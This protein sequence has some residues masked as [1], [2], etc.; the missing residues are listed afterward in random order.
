LD[1]SDPDDVDYLP[2][3]PW[4][5]DGPDDNESGNQVRGVRKNIQNT[6]GYT[7]FVEDGLLVNPTHP[8]STNEI[9]PWC[10]RAFCDASNS[11]LNCK[12]ANTCSE[13]CMVSSCTD[14]DIA[15]GYKRIELVIP[16]GGPDCQM[17]NE[18][19]DGKVQL[20]CK[21]L[22]ETGY[23]ETTP[24]LYSSDPCWLSGR[25]AFVRSDT[26]AAVEV[27]FI[28]HW[29]YYTDELYVHFTVYVDDDGESG[30]RQAVS[31]VLLLLLPAL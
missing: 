22:N 6:T 7:V 23:G 26:G 21:L 3:C 20:K 30:T 19:Q 10:R 28:R 2:I 8:T 24:Y 1:Y 14:T 18:A 29:S 15:G 27:Y 16:P 25:M 17:K 12:N 4:G 11:N 31:V 13:P 9:K 5:Q